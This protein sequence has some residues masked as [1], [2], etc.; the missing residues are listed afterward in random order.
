MDEDDHVSDT[1]IHKIIHSIQIK[2][3]T[4]MKATIMNHNKGLFDYSVHQFYDDAVDCK[5]VIYRSVD[6]Y[7]T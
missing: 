7:M 1:S 6:R 2:L 4:V 3:Q 5:C